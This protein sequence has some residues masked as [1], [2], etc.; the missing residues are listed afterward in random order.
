MAS[1]VLNAAEVDYRRFCERNPKAA[2]GPDISSLPDGY[3]FEP[4]ERARILRLMK[5]G[6]AERETERTRKAG[7]RLIHAFGRD[8]GGYPPALREIFDPPMLLYALGA[9]EWLMRPA[10]A[11]VGSRSATIYGKSAAES[12]SAQLAIQGLCVVSGFARGID[13]AAHRGALRVGGGTVAVLGCGVDIDYPRGNEDLRNKVPGKGCLISEFPMGTYPAKR[14]FPRRNRII[15]GLSMGVIVVEAMQNSGA[16][17]TARLASEQ[18]R[19]V[20]AVPGNIFAPNSAVPHRLLKD[21]AR[22]VESA[23]DVLEELSGR[24]KPTPLAAPGESPAVGTVEESVFK[25]LGNE[26]IHIDEICRRLAVPMAR[27]MATLSLLELKG[28]IRQMPGKYFLR[29]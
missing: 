3:Q 8:N 18:G 19:D 6:F 25:C 5:E 4:K 29:K 24:F 11:M 17:I 21:G 22:L 20:F 10:V 9:L 12:I 2:N 28:C 15:S 1:V 16:Q 23:Q 14:N 26:P 13:S 27:L 7:V